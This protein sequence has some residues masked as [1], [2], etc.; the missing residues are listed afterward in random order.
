MV[1]GSH[2]LIWGE[3]GL[4]ELYD[5]ATDPGEENNLLEE[6]PERAD[7]ML[8]YLERLEESL[9]AQGTGEGTPHAP[10]REHLEMLRGLGYFGEE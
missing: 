5:L 8:E 7:K 1:K 6:D 10:S 3:D 9:E 4:H 2:K